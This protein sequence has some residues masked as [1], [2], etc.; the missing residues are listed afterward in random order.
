VL[1]LN[2][3]LDGKG[4]V[5]ADFFGQVAD[6]TLTVLVPPE[7]SLGFF[8][9]ADGGRAFSPNL[10]L[11]K[12]LLGDLGIDPAA[13]WQAN[14]DAINAHLRFNP[15]TGRIEVE[16]DPG[17]FVPLAGDTYFSHDPT[18]NSDFR[19]DLTVTQNA[20]TISGVKDGLLWIGFEDLPFVGD[21]ATQGGS[22]AQG[23]AI[24]RIGS[25]DLDYND[26]LFSIDILYPPT[27]VPP[28]AWH[29]TVGI[30]GS[31]TQELDVLAR[32]TYTVSG[33]DG[34][35]V[36][37]A[38]DG[39]SLGWTLT[40]GA[41]V[42]AFGNG[43]YTL[44]PPGGIAAVAAM[45]AELAKI[46][47]LIPGDPGL[48]GRPPVDVAVTVVDAQGLADSAAAHLGFSQGPP[49]PLAPSD[50]AIHETYVPPPTLVTFHETFG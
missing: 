45:A 9:I 20:H 49:S 6:Q 7:T 28:A 25:N 12:D 36:A 16:T 10:A 40:P 4:G 42:D 24:V 19:D 8:L 48:I 33:L 3:S 30:F 18:L 21:I 29:P 15:V 1:W 13:S 50:I 11:F 38:H 41:D 17:K 2:A 22:A 5:A 47:V 31:L 39:L 32:A 23:D 37:L 26:L 43:T 35:G 34:D 46:A 44:T 14:L 27:P